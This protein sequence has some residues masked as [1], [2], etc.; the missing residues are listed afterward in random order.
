MGGNEP[1]R[2]S[3]GCV[4]W[5][6]A[7]L[8][9]R[10]D[11]PHPSPLPSRERGFSRIGVASYMKVA[12]ACAGGHYGCWHWRRRA[13]S[14]RRIGVLQTPALDRLAT[15]P[16]CVARTLQQGQTWCRGGDSN[17]HSQSGHSALNA[18]CLPIP[19]PRHTLRTRHCISS[20]F[21]YYNNTR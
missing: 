13:D 20:R 15:S 19:P 7:D 18:A 5:N 1:G 12:S 3:M 4:S 11:H 10:G 6:R 17:S 14:N 2:M 21:G 9:G 16:H 8:V